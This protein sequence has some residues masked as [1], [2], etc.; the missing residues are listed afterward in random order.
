MLN[1]SRLEGREGSVN[2]P[3]LFLSSFQASERWLRQGS[4][5]CRVGCMA[6]CFSPLTYRTWRFTGHMAAWAK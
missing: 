6:N 2:T 3:C 5:A 1:S 4:V